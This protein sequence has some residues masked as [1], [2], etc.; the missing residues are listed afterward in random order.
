M[1][2]HIVIL[3][4]ILVSSIFINTTYANIDEYINIEITGNSNVDSIYAKE[5]YTNESYNYPNYTHLYNR[6]IL[7]V[8]KEVMINQTDI[9]TWYIGNKWIYQADI[10]SDSE[11]GIFDLTSNDLTITV[12]D[13]TNITINGSTWDVYK[14][15]IFG[16]VSGS[17]SS[18]IISGDVDGDIIGNASIRRSDLSLINSNILSFGE[19]E[20]LLFTFDYETTNTAINQPPLEYFDF[21]LINNEMWNI[22]SNISTQS[23]IYV[24]GFYDNS[25]SSND[26]IEGVVECL[27]IENVSV[28]AGDF[29]SY[30]ILTEDKG[31]IESWYSPLSNNIIKTFINNTN[32]N[33]I[34]L[35]N[36]YLTSYIL[37]NPPIDVTLEIIPN[38]T[39]VGNNVTISGYCTNSTTGQPISYANVSIKI[40]I[41]D[42][43][44]QTN[45]NETGYYSYMITA[46]RIIDDT[47][48][49]YDLGSD[50]IIVTVNKNSSTGYKIKTL[51][52]LDNSLK[53][54]DLKNNWNLLSLTFNQTINKDNLSIKY[55]NNEYTWTE[56]IDPS[57]GP[58]IDPN[59]YG[60][61]RTSD[62]YF[63]VQD[64]IESGY[65]YWM[66]AY[67]DCELWAKNITTTN[68]NFITYLESSWNII[69]L[70]N[71]LQMNKSDFI[72]KYNDIEYSW[73]EATN[74]SNGPIIDPNIYGWNRTSSIYFQVIDTI[75]IGMVIGYMHT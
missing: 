54:T 5:S 73:S 20:Y 60:W 37:A 30:H 31:T 10:Y 13:I 11:N 70:P 55:N 72:I 63:Q 21:P 9:P 62:I 7:D 64:T 28:P 71:N 35:I 56:A 46:P 61:N 18:G 22:Y 66:Y 74:P 67:N 44:W 57:N 33:D 34:T 47:S 24:E 17:F 4:T 49:S 26:T 36:L 40:P 25:S 2:I 39:K 43:E 45:T 42:Q 51:T 58:I 41:T 75:N 50:G 16:N 27:G 48:T 23:Y 15:N 68:D 53:I 6:K 38:I 8:A 19:I 3:I 69:G 12:V 1:K 52:V 32:E 29:N 14:I 65:G 59:I